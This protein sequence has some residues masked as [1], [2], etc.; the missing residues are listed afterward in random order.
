MRSPAPV[1]PLSR[2][3]R[4]LR[5]IVASGAFL[6]LGLD[7]L[8]EFVGDHLRR[9]VLLGLEG[10]S[11][12]RPRRMEHRLQALLRR[13]AFAQRDE[14]PG[15]GVAGHRLLE[16]AALDEREVELVALV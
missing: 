1:W 16:V 2:A 13:L 11:H 3:K 8:F 7:A 6:G 5:S 9:L 4:N 10:G 14:P 12:E 15:P